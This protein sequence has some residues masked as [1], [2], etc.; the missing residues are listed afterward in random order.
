MLDP[1][2]SSAEYPTDLG[3]CCK[4]IDDIQFCSKINL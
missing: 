4:S 2:K 1:L 3:R